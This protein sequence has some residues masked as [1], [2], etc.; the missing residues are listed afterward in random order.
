MTKYRHYSSKIQ[1]AISLFGVI[2]MFLSFKLGE[3]FGFNERLFLYGGLALVLQ[4][5]LRRRVSVEPRGFPI[6]AVNIGNRVA[7]EEKEGDRHGKGA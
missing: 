4:I 6:S 2:L 7:A 5:G 3:V 1:V